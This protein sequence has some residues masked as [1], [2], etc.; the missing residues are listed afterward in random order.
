MKCVTRIVSLGIWTA[1]SL[2]AQQTPQLP[3]LQQAADK[4]AADWQELAKGLEVKV[5]RMLPCDPRVRT[6]IEEVSRASEA[7]FA[8]LGQYLTAAAAQAKD[9]SAM[10]KSLLANQEEMTSQLAAEQAQL[11][12]ERAG[13]EI[14]LADLS[15][16]A[17]RRQG[18]DDWLKTLT[19]IVAMTRQRAI[20]AEQQAARS[21]ELAALLR[22][23][24]VSA[25]AREG[26]LS[27]EASELNAETGGWR[28]YYA[29]RLARAQTE[30][31]VTGQ[32]RAP[33][34]GK[35]Q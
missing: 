35:K 7:R 9:D 15:E 5:A 1:V 18:L 27:A 22:N 6:S 20:E 31:V 4:A 32:G 26:A 34:P 17:K 21:Q 19:S 14:Q 29:A 11:E 13:I 25:E 2:M 16:S 10:V 12:Q 33:G 28:D 30:C 3:G 23:M 8:A 24:N